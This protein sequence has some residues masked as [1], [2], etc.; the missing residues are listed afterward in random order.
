M[1]QSPGTRREILQTVSTALAIAGAGCSVR[2]ESDASPN[3]ISTEPSKTPISEYRFSLESVMKEQPSN[4]NPARFQ[5]RLT[6]EGSKSVDLGYG[7][8]L[9]YSLIGPPAEQGKSF[10]STAAEYFII[11]PSKELPT[12]VTNPNED[13]WQFGEGQEQITPLP[14]PAIIKWRSVEP[15]KSISSTFNVYSKATN[16]ICYPP[17]E[18]LFRDSVMVESEARENIMGLT[19][20]MKVD[21]RGKFSVDAHP[22]IPPE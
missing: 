11:V 3:P 16:D 5:V 20:T 22:P 1:T 17:G 9:M 4:V 21:D 18:Y 10:S 12:G 19:I 13:C 2:R 15:S 7:V 8:E 6:N 14:I